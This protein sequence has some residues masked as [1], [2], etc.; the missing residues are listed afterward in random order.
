M[1]IDLSVHRQR[2]QIPLAHQSPQ[3][4]F[5]GFLTH[6]LVFELWRINKKKN[7]EISSAADERRDLRDT[8]LARE[9]VKY[10]R[11]LRVAT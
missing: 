8:R 11:T 5:G 6:T 7:H 3:T 4:N 1:P 10:R 9:C 2:S